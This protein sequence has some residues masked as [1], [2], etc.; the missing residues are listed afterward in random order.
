ML[1]CQETHNMAP[2]PT[3][4]QGTLDILYLFSD[5]TFYLKLSPLYENS[6]AS[7]QYGKEKTLR[8]HNGCFLS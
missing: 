8:D 7:G 2:F 6:E 4:G 3:D 1:R 5:S